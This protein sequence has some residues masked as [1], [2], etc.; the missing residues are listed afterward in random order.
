MKV[1]KV[2]AEYLQEPDDY[3]ESREMQIIKLTAE[4]VLL[5]LHEQKKEDYFIV[6]ET[7]RF[8]FNDEKEVI[9]LIR[10]FKKRLKEIKQ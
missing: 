9:D 1:G 10:D 7:K 8:A 6:I 3:D 2:T 5:H 4:P